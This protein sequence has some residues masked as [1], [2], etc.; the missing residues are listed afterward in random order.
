M[1]GLKLPLYNPHA[2]DRSQAYDAYKTR[3][4][5][6]AS[7][8]SG[9]VSF[10]DF[11]LG[12]SEED[13]ASIESSHAN[14]EAQLEAQL[15]ERYKNAENVS[16]RRE[17]APDVPLYHGRAM[18]VLGVDLALVTRPRACAMALRSALKAGVR[19]VDTSS[20]A[21]NETTI[22][23]A[24]AAAFTEDRYGVVRVHRQDVFV[25]GTLA[26]NDV[27]DVEKAYK[28]TLANLRL[29]YLDL[30]TLEWPC[31]TTKQTA[32]V[33][34][35]MEKLVADGLVRAIGVANFSIPK[36][37]ALLAASKV[38]PAVCHVEG[39]PHFRN[40]DLLRFCREN[41]VHVT[42]S[43][44]T[45]GVPR[46]K[47]AHLPPVA[48]APPCLLVDDTVQSIAE[49]R[50]VMPEQVVLRWALQRGTST[51]IP[52]ACV[53]DIISAFDVFAWSLGKE[54][55]ERLSSMQYQRRHSAGRHLIGRASSFPSYEH[56]WDEPPL[57]TFAA[58]IP[59]LKIP[60]FQ[61]GNTGAAI[62]QIG[63]GTWK[64]KPGE[65]QK[66]VEIALR[67]GYRHIDC[68]E[69]YR[70]EGEVGDAL[71]AVLSEGR[72]KREDVFLT[73]K[74]WNTDH[75]SSRV[76]PA[77]RKTLNAL[78]VDYLDLYLMH[79][80]V[81][82]NRGA[83]LSPSI[84]ETW[85]AMEAAVQKGL[86]RAIGVCNFSI[87]KLEALMG[88][89][90]LPVSVCQIEG[91]PYFRNEAL[92][93]WCQDR[94]IHV[95]CYSPFGS[96]DS[97]AMMRRESRKLLEEPAVHAIAKRIGRDVGQ[98]LVR[99]AIQRGVSTLPKSTSEKR[100]VSNLDV[101]TF[102]L[103]ASDMST[104]S[105]LSYQ[106]RMVDP[107]EW[108]SPSTGPY[109]KYE[110][111]WDEPRIPTGPPIPDLKIPT[112]QLGNTGAAIPQIGLGTWKSK[113]GEVQKAVEIALRNG[114]RHIDC[115][116]VYR[117]EG[118]VGDALAAVLSE[119]RL[120]R[121]DVFLTGKLWNTDH[122][123]S[124]VEPAVRKTLNAL[125]VDYLDLY[126]MHWPVTGNRGATLSPSIEE[127]WRAMEAAVQKGLV[128]AIGVCNFSIK[129]L[130]ALMGVARL[131]V[132]VC[133]IEGHPYFR[134][135][136]LVRWCQDRGIHVTCYSPFGSPDSAAMMRR[137]S[138]K[139][140]EE[141]AV[142]AIAKRIGRDVGQVLVR[143]AI[144]RGVS[145]L[146]KS[147]SEKRIVSN[148]DVYTF[149]LSASDMSTL[150]TLS[151]QCRMV[152]PPEWLSPSTGPYRKY[153]DLWDEPPPSRAG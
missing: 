37:E 38:R 58:P 28:N 145:T 96:P 72:L 94:G 98:V 53:A 66:A 10:F 3:P 16:W 6:I 60:T 112:F 4:D 115:A 40:D 92:V 108:L 68:A 141:P 119:G 76:E 125:K 27:H 148:L 26:P 34:K 14:Q 152:D 86:V 83:T 32:Q 103:S 71:A 5:I 127:T 75:A 95:T 55:M 91:H 11:T 45:G 36:L 122:A 130:E 62:P 142:H 147:T 18:P 49:R 116:E 80:P 153:E 33:W 117:N 139:L 22:G 12:L 74:L 109:R 1:K 17:R 13:I 2:L 24:F 85:R 84:E 128:R 113:P 129:K 104:L 73:G 110:D 106:C 44:A 124:R 118:E 25:A 43:H 39:H 78:K 23:E 93:R 126:L 20:S 15:A 107:P 42:V 65:V 114:Y 131:P 138:R 97:A 61:L 144:Q 57:D 111:L 7:S 46:P 87:K 90:R 21:G 100:I 101:Y 41:S 99:W 59:D 140:L 31:A 102:E 143:W 69:V 8:G 89:A 134:N 149:E 137:E 146:P 67:N 82:G 151:Y 50:D 29:K 123:S 47:S 51:L 64:S 132:S 121:E 48:G 81:T 88:V 105:T 30:Y 135:E 52:A 9:S 77:V 56:L 35:A 133:Q 70:N 54:E 19:R 150:S 79:W 136:A 63:L 120:K